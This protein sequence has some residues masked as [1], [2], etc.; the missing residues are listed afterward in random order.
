MSTITLRGNPIQVYGEIP[1]IGAEAP[2]FRLVSKDLKDL[3]LHDFAGKK[4]ILNIFPSVDTPVCAMSMKKFNDYAN[5]NPDVVMLQI[6]A[7]LP[8]AMNRFCGAESLT[9]LV[10]LSTM[11]GRNF[12]KDYGVLIESGPFAGICARACVVLSADNKVLHA[13]LV[14][15]IAHEPDYEAALK[16]LG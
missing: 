13:E 12:A 16:A 10:T 5:T 4:K 11:R 6:S 15:E 1:A 8:F 14:G 2:G 7:D 3:S 9:N